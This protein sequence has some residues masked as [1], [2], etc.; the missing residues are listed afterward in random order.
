LPNPNNTRISYI[1]V[2]G[3]VGLALKGLSSSKNLVKLCVSI[4]NNLL[5]IN[6]DQLKPYL[7][8]F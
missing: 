2:E 4:S 5:I 8:L 6:I 7:L 1:V 3:E